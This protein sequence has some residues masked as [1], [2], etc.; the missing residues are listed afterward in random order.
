MPSVN[1]FYSW[2]AYNTYKLV[3]AVL[4]TITILVLLYSVG[5]GA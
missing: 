2:Y 3:V 4:L 1:E 5:P